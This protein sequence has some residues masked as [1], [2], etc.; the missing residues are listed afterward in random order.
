MGWRFESSLR[1]FSFSHLA[2][3]FIEGSDKKSGPFVL[4]AQLRLGR[5]GS[6]AVTFHGGQSDDPRCGDERQISCPE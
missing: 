2:E 5:V 1:H 3:R 4:R 6:L